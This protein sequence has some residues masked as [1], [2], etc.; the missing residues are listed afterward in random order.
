MLNVMD[1]QVR[2]W[3]REERAFG[4]WVAFVRGMMIGTVIAAGYVAA[5]IMAGAA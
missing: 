1:K 3:R 4:L 2:Q 5:Q